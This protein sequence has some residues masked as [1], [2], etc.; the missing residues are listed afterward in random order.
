MTYGRTNYILIGLS[1]AIIII[2]FVLMSGGGSQDPNVFN[3]EIFSA[4]RIV[5]APAVCL[6]GFLL[7]IVAILIKPT[8]SNEHK[9]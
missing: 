1:I 3:P 6:S 7:M 2:G 9:D 4:R 8:E 5:L